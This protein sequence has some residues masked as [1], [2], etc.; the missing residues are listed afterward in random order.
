MTILTEA[1]RLTIAGVVQGVGFRPFIYRLACQNGLTGYVKNI[2]GSAVEVVLEGSSQDIERMV[3]QISSDKPSAAVIES[4]EARPLKAVG[5][6]EFRIVESDTSSH[7]PSNIPA[8]MAVCDE[9]MSEVLN[10]GSRWHGYPFN[11]CAVCGPRFSVMFDVPYDRANTSMREF[12]LCE[13]CS[14]DYGDPGNVRRF[15]VQGISCPRCGPSLWVEDARGEPI[16]TSDPISYVASRMEDGK[17]IAIKGLGG[18]HIACSATD[19]EVVRA[20]RSRKR[21]PSK[22]FAVMAL[23]LRV[24]SKLVHVDLRSEKV[25]ISPERPIVLLEIRKGSPLSPLVA[26]GLR[27]IGV[28]LPYTPLHH[29]LLKEYPDHFAIMTSGNPPGEPMCID[30]ACAKDKLSG[31]VDYFLLHNRKIVNRVDDSVVRFTDGRLSFLRRGRGYAPKWVR[32]PVKL[33]SPVICFGAMLQNAGAVAFDDKAVLTQY[34]GDTDEYFTSLELERY[35]ELLVRNY[36]IDVRMATVKHDLHPSYPSTK[37]AKDWG[38]RHGVQ[39]DAVQHHWAHILSAMAE[40]GLTEQ[41]IGIAID[42]TGYG[43]DGNIWGGEVIRCDLRGYSRLGHLSYVPLPGGDLAAMYPPRML[44][45][46]LSRTMDESDVIRFFH[47]RGIIDFLP[48]GEDELRVIFQQCVSGSIRTSSLGRVLD[49]AASLLGF[50]QRRTYE[51]EPAIKLEANSR[52]AAPLIEPIL[53]G[54]DVLVLDTSAI[55]QELIQLLGRRSQGVLAFS[56]Q[57]ALGRGLAEIAR[58]RARRGD[59]LLVVS[60]GAS[61]NTYI[62]KGITDGADERFRIVTNSLV[63]PGDGG[64]ALGQ[65]LADPRD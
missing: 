46:L 48:H 40:N 1:V 49:A 7:A 2:G 8:D 44:V 55:F 57:Y 23:D 39:P 65:C 21:R 63:P 34:I 19:D 31:F 17:A 6:R 50:C 61:V 25:L 20:L 36:R 4:I 10:P 53:G 11:S 15:H 37:M 51:G 22:P 24:A 62:M 28:F 38:R 41:A 13:E 42:G 64:I 14:R 29:L 5:F 47:R 32:L 58:A 56:L 12:H 18:F 26:P 54:S 27:H 30:E 33:A 45:S 60:G 35:L 3:T 16:T 43:D 59:R 9:C 52:E